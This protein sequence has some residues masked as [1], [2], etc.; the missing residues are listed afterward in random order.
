MEISV[1]LRLSIA[2]SGSG[3]RVVYPHARTR[4]ATPILAITIGDNRAQR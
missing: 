4:R 1:P 3:D 2:R